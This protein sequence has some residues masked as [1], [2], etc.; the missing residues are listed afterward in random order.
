[1][2]AKGT[3]REGE[4]FFHVGRRPVLKWEAIVAFIEA[5]HENSTAAIPHY[6]DRL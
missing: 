3:L 4:H 6:R 1:M 5:G 2:I